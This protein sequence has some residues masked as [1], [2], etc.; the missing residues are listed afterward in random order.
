MTWMSRSTL[1]TAAVT[2]WKTTHK[3]VGRACLHCLLIIA[4]RSLKDGRTE[5]LKISSSLRRKLLTVIHSWL[6]QLWARPWCSDSSCS[7]KSANNNNND[8]K[9]EEN[10]CFMIID[11]KKKMYWTQQEIVHLQINRFSVYGFTESLRDFSRHCLW[12]ILCLEI[13]RNCSSQINYPKG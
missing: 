3:D 13:R 6:L 1:R 2:N 9:K 12:F 7:F 4:L 10:T 5:H 8:N 11:K